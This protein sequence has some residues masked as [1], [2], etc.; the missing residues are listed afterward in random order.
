MRDDAGTISWLSV[1]HSGAYCPDCPRPTERVCPPN[2]AEVAA[3][4]VAV[5][6][7][8]VARP[9]ATAEVRAEGLRELPGRLAAERRALGY[10]PES[11][12]V[13]GLQCREFLAWLEARGIRRMETVKAAD[14][15]AYY[16]YVA[17]RPS[18]N[19]AGGGAMTPEAVRQHVRVVRALF[20][21]LV[22]G[23][24]LEDDPTT[25]V[26]EEPDGAGNRAERETLTQEQ[27]RELYAACETSRERA[28]VS[29]AYGC[30]VRVGEMVGLDVADVRLGEGVVVVRRGKGGRRR[31][32]PLG[33]G[34]AEDFGE[35]IARDRSWWL[36]LGDASTPALVV[37]DRGERMR[38]WTYNKRL[39]RLGERAGLELPV[40]CH[41]L[42][43]A[44]ATHL[45]ERGLKL[46]QVQ[47]FLGHEH[48]ATTQVYTH[49]SAAMLAQLVEEGDGHGEDDAN[50]RRR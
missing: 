43:H 33:A 44:I 6:E 23:G 45:L 49:V 50:D 11:C 27:V 2:R 24:E 47:L 8:D 39:R 12:R 38:K 31:V 15:R 7:S 22:A 42:R 19:D 16:E 17:T 30:G 37:G 35:Y 4:A 20:E 25:A 26:A 9:S 41:V 21:L 32:V 29:L 1:N 36:E 14:V 10:A 48:L 18:R 5:N 13:Y 28:I 40:T 3:E 46:A 34:V